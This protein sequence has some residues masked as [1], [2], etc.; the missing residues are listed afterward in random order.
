MPGQR[1]PLFSLSATG[2]LGG[3]RRGALA[4][5]LLPRTVYPVADSTLEGVPEDNKDTNYG[6]AS[7]IGELT[8]ELG[9][10]KLFLQRGIVR[11]DLR[12]FIGQSF[13]AA[14][15]TVFIRTLFDAASTT[16]VSRCVGPNDWKESEVTWNSRETGSPWAAGGGDFDDVGPPASITRPNPGGGGFT[17]LDGLLPFVT[18]ALTSRDGWL[19]LITRL[20]DEA[21]GT[22]EGH[23]FYSKEADPAFW[24]FLTLTP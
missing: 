2:L 11:F 5:V 9:G 1:A 8:I 20:T 6:S 24:P 17:T 22:S 14:S 23:D 13:S 21:P 12:S 7:V 10:T 3:H 15:L 4:P 19:S 18:D 16:I